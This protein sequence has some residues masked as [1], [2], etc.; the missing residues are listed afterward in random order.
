M[1]KNWMVLGDEAFDGNDIP[2][3]VVRFSPNELNNWK[4]VAINK[5][6]DAIARCPIVRE[7]ISWS[8][9]LF[10]D[11]FFHEAICGNVSEF[12][13]FI[14]ELKCIFGV[15]YSITELCYTDNK[16]DEDRLYINFGDKDEY[17]RLKWGKVPMDF[18]WVCNDVLLPVHLSNMWVC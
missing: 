17:Y 10:V 16:E 5:I 13:C 2:V 12:D 11:G 3:G 9:C 6:K 7:I 15:D 4:D 8:N 1:V 18:I 14:N